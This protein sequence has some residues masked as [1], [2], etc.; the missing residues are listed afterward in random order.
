[1]VL[2]LLPIILAAGAIAQLPNA[3]ESCSIALTSGATL[4][5][6]YPQIDYGHLITVENG[7]DDVAFIRLRNAATEQR[8]L[9][10]LARGERG[11]IEDVPD[12]QY[13]M[14]FAFGGRLLAD[15]ETLAQPEDTQ[16]FKGIRSLQTIRT[17]VPG[18]VQIE[19]GE[20]SFTL[21][22]VPHGNVRPV[23]ISVDEFNR[24]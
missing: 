11:A 4:S 5:G 10:Y 19:T 16:K 24:D 12:G 8:T 22:R 2:Q 18:G 17:E 21:H 23:S 6:A 13:E 14:L 15:C 3:A 9:M 1:M 20:W 7:T